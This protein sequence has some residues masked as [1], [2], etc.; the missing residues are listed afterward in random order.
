MTEMRHFAGTPPERV[1]M[2]EDKSAALKGVVVL[3]ST[4]LGPAAGGCRLW[5]YPT[6]EALHF[7]ALRLAEGMS[8]KTA[9]ADL[10]LGGGKA[11]LAMPQR[12]FDR[13]R[14]FEA[15]G[16]AIAELRG[17]YV[18]A[19]DVGTTIADMAAIRR[20]TDHVA[21]VDG[22]P[23][24]PAGDPSP[25]TAL[26][27][28]RAMEVAVRHRFGGD[29]GSLT[30]A[31]Q[32]LGNVGARLCAL[33]HAAGAR[34]IVADPRPGLAEAMEARYG[35]AI[36]TPGEIVG[37]PA[38][39][40]A[41]CALGA[42]L[43]RP[44]IA[45]LKAKLV[46]GGANNVLATPEDGDRLADRGILYAPDYVVNSGGII[47]VAAQYLGWELAE[48]ERRVAATGARLD[49]VLAQAQ[50][51]GVSPPRAADHMARSLLRN[52]AP[53]SGRALSWA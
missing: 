19:E 40:F 25:W 26:G 12:P 4:R 33:V 49:R 39:V 48:V 15:F 35:A 20:R 21:G 3:H 18:T 50:A 27:V 38:D 53:R 51:D 9:L 10:P 1:V 32:G 30:I 13:A 22:V 52:S 34:L 7:D 43:D 5:H 23:G 36:V 11:V 37:A 6:M 41:P 47:N 17:E 14:L 8:Y 16:R 31:V 46:C 45:S 2:I 24:R 28:F 29:L 44:A 42:V